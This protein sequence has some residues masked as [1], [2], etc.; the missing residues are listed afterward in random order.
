MHAMKK[1]VERAKMALDGVPQE[2]RRL[3]PNGNSEFLRVIHGKERIYPDTDTPP[4]VISQQVV[5]ECRKKVGKRPWEIY[6]EL[7]SK[8]SFNQHQ[9]D[10]LIRSEKVDRFHEYTEKL[11]L[12]GSLAYYLLIDLPR[13]KKRKGTEINDY[14]VDELAKGLSR[15]LIIP[16]QIDLLTEIFTKEP[17]LSIDEAA[18][19]IAVTVLEG[20]ALDRLIFQ[21]LDPFDKNKMRSDEAYRSVVIPKIVGEVLKSVN[22]SIEGK[23]VMERIHALIC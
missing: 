7:N 20:K 18:K 9:V 14:I 15:K 1:I 22:H 5:E 13:S 23:A 11:R 4:I 12:K 19:K 2:T 16:E 8:Y 17:K 10:L 21:K 3:L 6:E